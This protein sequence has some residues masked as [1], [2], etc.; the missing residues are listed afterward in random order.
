LRGLRFLSL[1]VL[2]LFSGGI[3]GQ[4]PAKTLPAF[5]AASVRPFAPPAGGWAWGKPDMDGKYF[6]MPGAPLRYIILTA[7]GLDDFQLTGLPDWAQHE[8]FTINATT[9]APTSPDQMLLM[10]QQLLVERFQLKIEQSEKEQSVWAIVAA[11]GGPKLKPRADDEKC[12]R[13]ISSDDMKAAGAPHNSMSGFNG[14]TMADLVKA[15]N[16]PGNVTQLGRPVIDKTALTGRYHMLVWQEL[17][18]DDTYTG[19]GQRYSYVE[20]FREAVE[21]ELGLKLVEDKQ[22]L[23]FINVLNVARPGPN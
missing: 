23:N 3:E 16:R 5:D 19:S 11:S 20:P 8:F 22:K 4:Q 2:G 10:L 17:D 14:C 9:D 18:V 1:V 6:R 12:P 21:K 7:Y 15:F 13:Y